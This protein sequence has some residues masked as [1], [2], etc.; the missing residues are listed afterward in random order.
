M[1]EDFEKREGIENTEGTEEEDFL[2]D[3]FD[4]DGNQKTFEH[5]DS[6]KK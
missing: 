6:A 2:I 1:A 4:E 5:L 3:L